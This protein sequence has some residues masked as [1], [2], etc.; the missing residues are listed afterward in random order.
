MSGRRRSLRRASNPPAPVRPASTSLSGTQPTAAKRSRHSLRRA[1]AAAS[2]VQLPPHVLDTIVQQ[3]ADVVSQRLSTSATPSN[4][5]PT[6]EVISA[7]NLTEVP[8]THSLPV[9][10]GS[11]PAPAD[12]N[13]PLVAQATLT[14]PAVHTAPLTAQ[15]TLTAPAV[16]NAL[17]AAQALTGMRPSNSLAQPESIFPSPSLAVDSRVSDKTKGKIWN[18]EYIDISLLPN[19]PV[20]EDKFQLTVNSLSGAGPALCLE[21]V[22]RPKKNI[23]IELWISCF[24]VFVGVYCQKYPNEA[25]ALMKYGEVVQDLAARGV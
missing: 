21:P 2:Q 17:L 13:A 3:V 18:N 9:D 1:P 11:L 8:V 5:T 24:H 16:N 10:S 25:P 4:S 15:A 12:S 23:S 14:S 7:S 6:T 19:N 22:S 20:N